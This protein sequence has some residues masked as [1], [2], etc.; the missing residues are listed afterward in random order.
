MFIQLC[1]P[2]PVFLTQFLC[3]PPRL[4]FNGLQVGGK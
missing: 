1:E 3:E 4:S 2:K